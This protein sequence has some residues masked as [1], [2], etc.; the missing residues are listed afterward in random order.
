MENIDRFGTALSSLAAAPFV[1][2]FVLG[3]IAL[4]WYF[5]AHDL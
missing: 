2:A 3:I 1:V 5:I 4:L